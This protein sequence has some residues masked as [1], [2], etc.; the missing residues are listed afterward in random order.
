MKKRIFLTT[1]KVLILGMVSVL[2]A[3]GGP[4]SSPS[5][6]SPYD[7][8]ASPAG[9]AQCFTTTASENANAAS[10]TNQR[11]AA[12]GL[13]RVSANDTLARAAANHACDMARRGLMSHGGSKTSGPSQRIKALGYAPMVTAENIAAGPYSQ[14]RVLQEWN[15]SPSHLSNILIPQLKD[16]GIGRAIGSDG[17]TTFWAIVYSASR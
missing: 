7:V 16:V 2:A 12:A 8:Q 17:K 10:A 13:G 3:C 9:E 15:A 6:R 1:P 4:T 5:P 11:R 14:S